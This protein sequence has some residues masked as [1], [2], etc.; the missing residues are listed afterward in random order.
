MVLPIMASA[1]EK[2]QYIRIAKIVVDS[3]KLEAYNAA[4]KEHAAAAVKKEPG[5]ILLYAVQDKTKLTNIT[6][7]EI[8][9]SIEAYQLHIQTDHFKKYKTT[10][11]K[12][13][14]SLVLTDVVPVALERKE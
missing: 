11:E 10:V 5:V 13:V 9:A 7:F 6:V 3:T 1:Q 8:Y 14:T 2:S 12:M 4:L